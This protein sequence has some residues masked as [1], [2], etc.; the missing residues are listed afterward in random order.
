MTLDIPGLPRSAGLP[1]WFD[2][3]DDRT[4]RAAWSRLTE[5]GDLTAAAFV[6][7]H[8]AAATL[9]RVLTVA[10]AEGG[11]ESRWLARLPGADPRRD[12]GVLGRLGGRLGAPRDDEGAGGPDPVGRP[13]PLCLSGS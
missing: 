12:L 7:R 2:P 9:A 3:D 5:P 8:G 11:V 10:G 13:P 6:R 1:A 4:A